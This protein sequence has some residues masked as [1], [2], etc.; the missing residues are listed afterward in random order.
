MRTGG[1]GVCHVPRD[2]GISASYR[3]KRP[4]AAQAGPWT[5]HHAR[6]RGGEAHRAPRGGSDRL[7]DYATAK[8]TLALALRLAGRVVAS[9]APPLV[10]SGLPGVLIRSFYG[11]PGGP[12]TQNPKAPKAPKARPLRPHKQ[13]GSFS[14]QRA[15]ARRKKSITPHAAPGSARHAPPMVRARARGSRGARVTSRVQAA[16][17]RH[18]VARRGGNIGHLGALAR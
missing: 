5:G 17:G 10:R 11:R 1:G 9:A 6:R 8:P 16:L 18:G 2:D 14:K 4:G 15:R 3:P 12:R 13:N 7:C